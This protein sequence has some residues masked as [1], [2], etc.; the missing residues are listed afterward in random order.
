MARVRD[1]VDPATREY[2]A[3]LADGDPE[4]AADFEH[5]L[6]AR[7]N[8]PVGDWP[9]D[10][11]GELLEQRPELEDEIVRRRLGDVVRR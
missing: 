7:R 8:D 2:F 5:P 6:G 4:V 3:L 11:L 1:L 9:S 10:R